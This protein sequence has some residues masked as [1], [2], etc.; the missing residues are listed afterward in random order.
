[1]ATLDHLSNGRAAWNIV[2]SF[3]EA[4]A[5]N[6]GRN[7]QLSRE[8]RYDRADEFMQVACKL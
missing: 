2:T 4:E 6:F 5:R 3:Q 1:M 8:Q 7:D